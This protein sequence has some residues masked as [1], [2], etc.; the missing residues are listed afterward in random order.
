MGDFTSGG[1]DGR[2]AGA[3]GA[4]RVLGS[5]VTSQVPQTAF[6]TGASFVNEWDALRC[7]TKIG[8]RLINDD[9]AASGVVSSFDIAGGC[10]SG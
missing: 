10:G 8:F 6:D 1:I 5:G 7:K 4:E 9:G 2:L 3:F